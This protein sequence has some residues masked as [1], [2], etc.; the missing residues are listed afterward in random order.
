MLMKTFDDCE[1]YVGMRNMMIVRNMM[2][3]LGIHDDILLVY[4]FQLRNLG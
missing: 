1:E 4:G 3:K 2:I